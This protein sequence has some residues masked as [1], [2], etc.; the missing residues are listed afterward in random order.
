MPSA[1][2]NSLN[3]S[4]AGDSPPHSLPASQRA[5]R[6]ASPL[7]TRLDQP[8]SFAASLKTTGRP[9]TKPSECPTHYYQIDTSLAGDSPPSSLLASQRAS[10]CASPLRTRLDQPHAFSASLKTS[11]RRPPPP[12]ACPT[13][14]YQSDLSTLVRTKSAL[15]G[16]GPKMPYSARSESSLNSARSTARA[17]SEDATPRS[18]SLL[19]PD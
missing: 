17:A 5:S 15:F 11:A 16:T 4:V 10:R 12:S 9:P 3:A 6:C 18:V 1:P 2:P 19:G 13:H 7:R 14:Y 8:H